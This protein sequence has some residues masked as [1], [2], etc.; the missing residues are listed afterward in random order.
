[1]LLSLLL[2]IFRCYYW[3]VQ[4]AILLLFFFI[5]MF[6]LLFL[7]RFIHVRHENHRN[8]SRNKFYIIWRLEWDKRYCSNSSSSFLMPR[9]DNNEWVVQT[10][11][12]SKF[13]IMVFAEQSIINSVRYHL[14]KLFRD[15]VSLYCSRFVIFQ[16]Y[17][18]EL[19]SSLL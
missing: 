3:S 5:Y 17:I 14:R 16:S 15:H 8:L 18:S 19:V 7:K 11:L 9:L 4:V 6:H 10:G 13:V 1:M 12:N 2:L